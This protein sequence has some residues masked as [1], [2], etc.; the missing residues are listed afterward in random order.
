M[1]TDPNAA[2]SMTYVEHRAT[3]LLDGTRPAVATPDMDGRGGFVFIDTKGGLFS[4]SNPEPVLLQQLLVALDSAGSIKVY[5]VNLD[6]NG[7]P[8]AAQ[9][10]LLREYA[11]TKDLALLENEFRVTVQLNQALQVVCDQPGRCAVWAKVE[12]GTVR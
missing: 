10:F 8:V 11:A 3:T 7:A 6:D 5:L 2:V 12:R 1:R 9:S 4:W